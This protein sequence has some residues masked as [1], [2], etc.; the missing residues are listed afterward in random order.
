MSRALAATIALTATLALPAGA[1]AHVEFTTERAPAGSDA[2]L[3]LEVP[4]ERPA[5][6]TNRID[7]RMPAAVTSVKAR[8]LHRWQLEVTKS[9]NDV[10]R[11]TLTAA[12]SGD[13]LTGTEKG[14]FGLL[15][16]L[17]ARP[18]TTIVFPVLQTYDDGEVV[19]WIGPEGTSEPAPRLRLTAAEKVPPPEQPSQPAQPATTPADTTSNKEGDGDGGGGVPIVVGIGAMLLAAVAGTTLARRRNR[20]RMDGR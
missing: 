3:T 1:V 19:R 4:N 14:R 16:G 8:A 13:E 11:V 20:R 9:G 10:R 7:I 5:A 17:P 18:G 6:A 2:R 15:V 12:P